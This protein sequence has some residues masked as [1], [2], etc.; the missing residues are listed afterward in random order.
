MCILLSLWLHTK[1][2]A[3]IMRIPTFLTIKGYLVELVNDIV[4]IKK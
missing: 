3:R 4:S 2:L 1:A